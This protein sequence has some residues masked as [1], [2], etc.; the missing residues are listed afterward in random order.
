VSD[1]AAHLSEEVKTA[2]RAVPQAMMWSFFLNGIVGFVVLIAF[3]FA[4]PSIPNVFDPAQNV[5]GSA[6]LYTFQ[7][8]SYWGAMPLIVIV[9]LVMITGSIDA[10]AST[11]R[12]T[13][14]FARDGGLPFGNF[15]AK[16]S[17]ARISQT[18]LNQCPLLTGE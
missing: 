16:V 17:K 5:S 7:N 11:S 15:L 9:M 2:S 6:F 13:F 12:Q 3:L 14:A 4:I 18:A 8:A 1:S 10:N